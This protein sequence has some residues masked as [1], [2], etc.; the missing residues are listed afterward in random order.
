LSVWDLFYFPKQTGSVGAFAHAEALIDKAFMKKYPNVVV[1]HVGVPISAFLPGLRG[2]VAAHSGPDVVVDGGGTFA[3][4]NGFSKG[5][6]PMYRLLSPTQK[7]QLAPYL[8]SEG[9][10]DPYHYAMP[11]QSGA[12]LF[13]YNKS[14]FAQAHIAAPPKTFSQLL[15]DCQALQAAN[16]TP[17]ANGMNGTTGPVMWSFGFSAEFLTPT[18]LSQWASLTL[19]QGWNT[20][21]ILTGLTDVQ[22]MAAKGCFGNRQTAATTTDTDG[23]TAF[24]G[25]HGAM[26]FQTAL[27][28]NALGGIGGPS[29][30]GVFPFPQA[31]GSKYPVGTPETGYNANWSIMSYT[32]VCSAAWNYISFYDSP[33]AQAIQWNVGQTPPVN[34]DTRIK[35]SSSFQASMLKYIENR[36]GHYGLGA[37]MSSPEATLLNQ[38]YPELIS[39]AITPEQ[40]VAQEQS[41]RST[42]PPISFTKPNPGPCK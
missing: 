7:K 30:V 16:I 23:A 31:P 13:N 18:Q 14:L 11:S 39:G 10:G 21:G 33:Q 4:T 25:G 5:M 20:P 37:T 35:A 28:P 40:L 8:A 36:Y 29:N 17:I 15:S 27:L 42:V 32:K 12:Y 22:T 24:L 26:L 19:P 3:Q 1:H 2:F 6:Y 38:L 34:I 41:A 9:N